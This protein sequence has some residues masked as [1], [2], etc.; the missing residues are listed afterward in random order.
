VQAA[1]DLAG[2]ATKPTSVRGLGAG[3]VDLGQVGF[4]EL[5]RRSWQPPVHLLGAARPHD[6]ARHPRLRRCPGDRDRTGLHTC[7][8]RDRIS[9]SRRARLRSS[10]GGSKSALC[11]RQSSCNGREVCRRH[12]FGEETGAHRA[13]DD[14]ARTVDRAPGEKVCCRLRMYE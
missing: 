11:N 8:L 13:V 6:R 4:R 5:D 14:D 9:A 2:P 10:R 1:T 7:P 3:P 12:A